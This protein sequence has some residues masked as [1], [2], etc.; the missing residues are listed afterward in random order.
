[1]DK[2]IILIQNIIYLIKYC[3]IFTIRYVSHYDTLYDI[4]ILSHSITLCLIIFVL[5]MSSPIYAMHELNYHPHL[6]MF[7]WSS[8]YPISIA[9]YIVSSKHFLSTMIT[10]THLNHKLYESRLASI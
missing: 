1:M 7:A 2:L 10:I 5:F 8:I 9:Y 3:V 4:F 6:S